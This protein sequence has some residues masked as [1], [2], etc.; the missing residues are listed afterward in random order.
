MMQA[1]PFAP[2]AAGLPLFVVLNSRSG[3]DDAV[4]ERTIIQD[5]LQASGRRHEV[6]LC[7]ELGALSTTVQRAVQLA[8]QHG[9]AVV[10][11]GG[12]GTI[13]AVAQAALAAGCP[14]G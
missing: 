10:A 14:M 1:M 3:S 11:A 2:S 13:N 4:S 6:L 9:G 7:G 12:D 8:R 5:A